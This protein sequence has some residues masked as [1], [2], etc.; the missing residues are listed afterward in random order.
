MFYN[1]IKRKH[2]EHQLQNYACINEREM[3]RFAMD[4]VSFKS[5]MKYCR[6]IK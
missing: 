6:E 1:L 5:K 4:F 2:Q 3:L